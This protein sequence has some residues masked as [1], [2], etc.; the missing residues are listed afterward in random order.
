V[1]ENPVSR[2]GLSLHVAGRKLLGLWLHLDSP[3]ECLELLDLV[4]AEDFADAWQRSVYWAIGQV[5][6]AGLNPTPDVVSKY[7]ALAADPVPADF[8]SR[9]TDGL[10]EADLTRRAGLRLV[11]QL[12]ADRAAAALGG[13][14]KPGSAQATHWGNA[15]R[16]KQRW[17]D[18]WLYCHSRSPRGWYRWNGARWEVDELQAL[19][20][21]AYGE[22]PRQ[23][24]NEAERPES[25]GWRKELLAWAVK[26]ECRN[27]V[28]GGIDAFGTLV[29]L[30]PDAFDSDPW[31]FGT[32][33][34]TVDLRTG[35]ARP[36]QRADFIT[37]GTA[38]AWDAQAECP[39]WQRALEQWHPDESTRAFLHRALGLTLIGTHVEKVLFFLHG[40]SGDNGKSVFTETIRKIFG[41]YAVHLETA[42]LLEHPNGGTPGAPRADIAALRGARLVTVQETKE[43]GRFN[44]EIVKGLTGGDRISARRPHGVDNEEWDPTHTLW[45]SGNY[46]PQL[47]A[48]SKTFN[49]LLKIP[50]LQSF[51]KGHPERDDRLP[52]A[53]AAELPGILRW[54]VEGCR[55]YLEHG[56]EPPAGVL[57]ATR[58]M[59]QAQDDLGRFLDDC[60]TTAPPLYVGASELREA[61]EKWASAKITQKRFGQWMRDR[62]FDVKRG[63]G[64]RTFFWGLELR[65][66][67]P[68]L[69]EREREP[70]EEG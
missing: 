54:C 66:Q 1:E 68:A 44:D 31:L 63:I 14:E 62:G 13:P 3:G 35:E 65:P 27:E 64:G 61:F 58:L 49:R 56:L 39:R 33:S 60:C 47:P 16:M 19:K 59:E 18:D 69:P 52:E 23:I 51:P 12:T 36:P 30:A 32:G 70:G 6:A 50:W 57:S 15:Q 45:I 10:A 29:P 22:L 67:E 38:V 2:K 21:L 5:R 4:H 11:K 28:S 41:S 9:L 53:L 24:V 17:G 42:S 8:V 7:A 48:G 34:L 55:L 25:A 37:R 46:E 20:R 43:G 26:S 40:A